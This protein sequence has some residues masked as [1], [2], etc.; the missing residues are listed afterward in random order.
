[1]LIYNN[2]NNKR[3]MIVPSAQSLRGRFLRRSFEIRVEIPKNPFN[4]IALAVSKFT[5]VVMAHVKMLLG[6]RTSFFQK[7]EKIILLLSSL[8]CN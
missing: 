5:D 2:N 7:S 1:M 8:T 3:V 6:A 4:Q